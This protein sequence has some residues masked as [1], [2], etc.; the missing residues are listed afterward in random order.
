MV[1]ITMKPNGVSVALPCAQ[2][3]GA[4]LSSR[5]H[6]ETVVVLA[7][8]NTAIKGGAV[9]DAKYGGQGSRAWSPPV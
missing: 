6:V 4:A 8:D 2:I 1:N 3:Q 7:N 9:G 5:L